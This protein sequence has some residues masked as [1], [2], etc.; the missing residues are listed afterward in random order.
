MTGLAQGL[1]RVG[2]DDAVQRLVDRGDHEAGIGVGI[3][4]GE[5][6]AAIAGD[7]VHEDDGRIAVGGART[8]GAA[9]GRGVRHTEQQRHGKVRGLRRH[10]IEAGQ[11]A[12]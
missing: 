5:R 3:H 1:R 11:I 4:D 6:V 10:R 7:A 8:A 12:A 9:V 2:R